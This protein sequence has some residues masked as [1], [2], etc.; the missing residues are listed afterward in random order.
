MIIGLLFIIVAILIFGVEGA[1][2]LAL[3]IGAA[4]LIILLVLANPVIAE[5]SAC[6]GLI[7]WI[8]LHARAL[9][10]ADAAE[11]LRKWGRT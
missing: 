1:V 7:G 3:W 11:R 2:A 8:I 10:T 6:I 4:C 5:W 9:N